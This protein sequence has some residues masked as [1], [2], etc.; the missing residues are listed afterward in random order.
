VA[1]SRAQDE[2]RVQFPAHEPTAAG[3]IREAAN[4]WGDRTLV[5]LDD[6]RVTYQEVE[7]RS[8]EMARALLASG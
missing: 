7:R 2:R 5:V 8:A 3:L 1:D 4:R 6:Q